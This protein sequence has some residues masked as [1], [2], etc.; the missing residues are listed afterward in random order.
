M[1]L[2]E[3]IQMTEEKIQDASA[4]GDRKAKYA[5]MRSKN[6][7]QNALNK[8][9]YGYGVDLKDEE[10]PAVRKVTDRAL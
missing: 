2:Q 8:L 3:E 9:K 4:D 7:L 1:M 10:Q 5:L 6:Q